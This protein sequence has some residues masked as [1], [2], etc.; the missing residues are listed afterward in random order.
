MVKKISLIYAQRFLT[1]VE[2]NG[3]YSKNPNF[4]QS[5]AVTSINMMNS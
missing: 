2:T 3:R 5:L 1:F 4:A